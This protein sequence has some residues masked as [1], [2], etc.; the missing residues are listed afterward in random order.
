MPP[1]QV[2]PA[3]GRNRLP[4]PSPEPP[5]SVVRFAVAPRHGNHGSDS[6]DSEYSSQTT[7]SGIS[8][9][10]R[11]YEAPPGAGG[12]A[13]RVMVEATEHPV[14]AR[15]TVRPARPP[16]A[17]PEQQARQTG[18]KSAG[19]V[20]WTP[21]RWPGVA[22]KRQRRVAGCH[23]DGSGL[24]GPSGNGPAPR[25]WLASDQ[26]ADVPDGARGSCS[27]QV[28]L[29]LK[30]QRERRTGLFS[31]RFFFEA[32][33][34]FRTIT[35]TKRSGIFSWPARAI[36]CFSHVGHLSLPLVQKHFR[37]Y[38]PWLSWKRLGPQVSES[39]Q[40]AGKGQRS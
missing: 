11:Q 14:F 22:R 21:V 13:H 33:C 5:P 26:A 12:L 18:R 32:T 7:V 16:P 30:G 15:S 1:A 34:P 40:G 25:A 20:R 27:G 4:T 2:S 29:E 19:E 37:C 36:R 9:E 31:C 10:L 24:G 39:S 3:H 6:S 8:E 28:S 38:C 23:S 35:L 17:G